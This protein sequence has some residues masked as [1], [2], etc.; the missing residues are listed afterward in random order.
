MSSRGQASL[1]Y[2]GVVAL[3]AVVLGL[4]GALAQAPSLGRSVVAGMARGLCV[5]RGGAC[6]TDR[7]PCPTA[8]RRSGRAFQGAVA[9]LR[10][11][12]GR[13]VVRESR[14]DGTVAVTV[15]RD[16]SGGV[17][18][19]HLM[20]VGL[21]DVELRAALLA[22]SGDGRTWEFPDAAAADRFLAARRRGGDAERELGP[23]A[24]TYG[25]RVPARVEAVLRAAAHGLS[26][27]AGISA[28]TVR[29]IRRDHRTGRTTLY[30]RRSTQTLAAAR[31][32][33]GHHDVG[34]RLRAGGS[35]ELA[36]TL[37]GDGRP[38]TLALR[39]VDPAGVLPAEARAAAG[40]LPSTQGAR[41]IVLERRLDLTD[42]AARRVAAGY[43]SG[44]RGPA[45]A[46]D[47]RALQDHLDEHAVVHVRAYDVSRQRRAVGGAVGVG[48]VMVGAT[49]E[50][51][52]ER[53]RLIGAITR[54]VGGGWSRRD[55]CLAGVA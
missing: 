38:L 55:D 13:L 11:G 52:E 20:G 39:R 4:G 28:E 45:A 26:L 29:G 23:P 54:D 17:E 27:E 43:L 33:V 12:Q 34:P 21:A 2:V 24:A 50:R 8:W 7:E 35:E 51:E 49:G 25:E 40:L 18:L 32:R 46:A 36:L 1:E 6:E 47:D 15:A 3:V 22:A 42:P 44:R 37:A 41:T 16:T 30:L 5:V 9:L 14:S 48:G 19:G 53:A 10:L 31:V